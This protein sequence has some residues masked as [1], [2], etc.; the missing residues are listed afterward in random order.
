VLTLFEPDGDESVP[1]TSSMNDYV[2]FL[3]PHV[4]EDITSDALDLAGL[5]PPEEEETKE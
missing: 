2:F 4:A 5:T 3:K 1:A